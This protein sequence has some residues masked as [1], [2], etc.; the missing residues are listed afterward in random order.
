MHETDTLRSSE[1]EG[2]KELGVAGDRTV[3]MNST[4]HIG[5]KVVEVQKTKEKPTGKSFR[6]VQ[7]T[8]TDLPKANQTKDEF[9]RKK[10][11]ED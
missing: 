1:K 4:M 6:Q 8:K 7:R 3:M 10:A 9:G 5:G 2:F 11:L